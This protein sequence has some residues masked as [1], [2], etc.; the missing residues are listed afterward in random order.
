MYSK[1]RAKTD[2]SD[3]YVTYQKNMTVIE[4]IW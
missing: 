1:G 2:K 3:K 4:K